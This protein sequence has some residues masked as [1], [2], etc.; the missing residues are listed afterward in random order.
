M[1]YDEGE[2]RRADL[3]LR[4]EFLGLKT[5]IYEIVEYQYVI[6]LENYRVNFEE[7]RE[8]FERNIRPAGRMITLKSKKPK[9]YIKQI[10]SLEFDNLVQNHEGIFLNIEM[11]KSLIVSRFP[12]VNFLNIKVEFTQGVIVIIEVDEK[13]KDSCSDLIKDFIMNMKCG[14]TD[15]KVVKVNAEDKSTIYISDVGLAC[16][17]KS[18]LFSKRDS[19]FWFSRAEDIYRGN[20]VRNDLNFFDTNKS[21]CYLD[22][23]IWENANINLR[24]TMLLYDTT[25][26]SFPLGGNT[27]KF[28][29]SQN[30]SK[31]D[32]V[33]MVEQNKLVVFLPNTESRYDSDIL[34]EL[35]NHNSNSVISKRGINALIAMYFCE[36]EKKYL[37]SFGDSVDILFQIYKDLKID[38]NSTANA[39]AEWLVWPVKAKLQ[40][41]ELFNSYGPMKLPTIGANRLVDFMNEQSKGSTNMQFELTVNSGNIHIA[42]ALQATYFPFANKNK[43]AS[44]YSDKGVAAILGNIL[45]L[46]NYC[47]KNEQQQ[48]DIY[49]NI[50]ASYESAIRLLQIDNTVKIGKFLSKSIQYNTPDMLKQILV[51]LGNM[52]ELERRSRIADYNNVIAELGEEKEAKLEKTINYVLS[53]AGFIPIIGTPVSIVSLVKDLI[54]EI[55]KIQKIKKKSEIKNAI[56]KET[57]RLHDKEFLDEVYLL[58]RLSRIAKIQ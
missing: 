5:N 20:A 42:T 55:N 7:I 16:T 24:S 46:Y 34:N 11:F 1:A 12:E 58:D 25:F 40:S 28:L 23:S 47:K 15:V 41:Y 14:Y 38:R 31:N 10:P 37:S 48:I 8:Y 30:I 3:K 21:K 49:A 27:F 36:L 18:Y 53:G 50:M 4:T 39:L 19:E 6:Q 54:G 29:Q 44:V 45:N 22:F 9:Q 32:L 17:D 43:D 33:E 57:K 26:I 56:K 52:G 2:V 35:Y 51:N 13:T